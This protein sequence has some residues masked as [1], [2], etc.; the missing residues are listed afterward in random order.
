MVCYATLCRTMYN[1]FYCIVLC[2]V[3]SYCIVPYCFVL[4]CIV[5]YHTLHYLISFYTVL[6]HIVMYNAYYDILYT[7]PYTLYSML[8]TLY[9]TILSFTM[10]YDTIR[11]Y[12]R[13]CYRT[14]H[15]VLNTWYKKDI[16]CLLS[17]RYIT[18]VRSCY[19]YI[20]TSVIFVLDICMCAGEYSGLTFWGPLW[21]NCFWMWWKG[22]GQL[23]V[24]EAATRS[25][26]IIDR[27]KSTCL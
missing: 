21:L 20:C 16:Q 18:C 25:K 9:H 7:T 11:Y 17:I 14:R 8:Y 23:P 3:V 12:T 19:I 13:R 5:L 4:Y 26:T 2:C 10:L 1:V 6:Y 15:I 22:H 27:N 24:P